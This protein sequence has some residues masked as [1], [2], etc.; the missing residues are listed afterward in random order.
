M[1]MSK[2][3]EIFETLLRA[4][5][6]EED[7]QAILDHFMHVTLDCWINPDSFATLVK[8]DFDQEVAED[9][10]PTFQIAQLLDKQYAPDL[11]LE[12]AEFGYPWFRA[13]ALVASEDD[14]FLL[15]RERKVKVKRPDGTSVWE[16]S[17]K[18]KWNLPSGRLQPGESYKVA[19][20]RETLEE[21]GYTIFV[22]DPCLIAHRV[23]LDNPYEL[24]IFAAR[25]DQ[26]T[27]AVRYDEEEIAEIRWFTRPQIEELIRDKQVR[28][29]EMILQTLTGYDF[30]HN[31]DACPYP[32]TFKPKLELGIKPLSPSSNSF[33]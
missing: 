25:V 22:G 1:S 6:T 30:Q 7:A 24:Q 18:G 16:V 28:N 23:D 27:F 31:F 13:G 3:Q 12:I 14:Q 8:K 10:I 33:D 15:V 20:S 29:A 26:G 4:K 9:I 17:D 32:C 11:A 21:T 2:T 19:A 5:Y